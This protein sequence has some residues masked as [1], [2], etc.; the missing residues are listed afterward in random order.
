[1]DTHSHLWNFSAQVGGGEVLFLFFF[2]CFRLGYRVLANWGIGG[3]LSQASGFVVTVY[4]YFLPIIVSG[5]FR[6]QDYDTLY[7]QCINGSVFLLLFFVVFLPFLGLLP[8]H[9]EVPRLG[10]ELE[11]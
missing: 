9:M 4:F 5:P 8:W 3:H 11:L 6:Y 1:M 7:G 10:V 2:F